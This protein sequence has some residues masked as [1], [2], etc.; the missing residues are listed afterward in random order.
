M[1]IPTVHTL[2]PNYPLFALFK[3]FFKS[4][5]YDKLLL[6]LKI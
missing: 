3:P 6:L 1:L 4:K 5:I 2:S